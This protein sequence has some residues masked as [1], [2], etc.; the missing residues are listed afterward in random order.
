M[1]RPTSCVKCGAEIAPSQAVIY[2]V[3]ASCWNAAAE[4]V[5]ADDRKICGCTQDDNCSE[6]SE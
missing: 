5:G 3:C 1:P 4:A 6:C 2:G